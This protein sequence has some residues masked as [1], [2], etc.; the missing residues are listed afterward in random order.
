MGYPSGRPSF[1]EGNITLSIEIVKNSLNHLR[2]LVFD[3]VLRLDGNL[4]FE[5]AGLHGPGPAIAREPRK[6]TPVHQRADSGA[7][8][9][10]HWLA[11][12]NTRGDGDLR[13]FGGGRT[14]RERAGT[15]LGNSAV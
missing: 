5:L 3:H 14:H 7:L 13:G 12:P 4:D 6:L 2:T 1:V 10:Q 11:E 15:S 9:Q 8:A